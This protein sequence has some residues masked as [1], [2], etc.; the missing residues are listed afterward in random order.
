MRL[1]EPARWTSALATA[2]LLLFLLLWIIV[3]GLGVRAPVRPFG[4]F[5]V[6]LWAFPAVGWLIFGLIAIGVPASIA[7]AILQYRLYDI[8]RS[9]SRTAVY[10]LVAAILLAG[11]QREIDGLSP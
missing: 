7:V 4:A 9:I 2:L 3:V 10:T 5:A 6:S 1:P 8:D 11:R